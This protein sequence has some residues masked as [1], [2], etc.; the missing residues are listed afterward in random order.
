MVNTYNIITSNILSLSFILLYISHF[1]THF[2]GMCSVKCYYY[3]H[4]I[5]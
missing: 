4:L 5:A 1:L 2:D 3:S